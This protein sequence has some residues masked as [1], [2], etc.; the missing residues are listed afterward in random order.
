MDRRIDDT[1]IELQGLKPSI[2]FISSGGHS[3][4]QKNKEGERV[5][6]EA[7][8]FTAVEAAKV[9]RLINPTAVALIGMY[10]HSI[11]KNRVEY[12][13]QSSQVEEEFLWALTY[14]DPNI[15][16]LFINPGFSIGLSE[17]DLEGKC[18]YFSKN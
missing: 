8:I 15:K 7:G 12:I 17:K 6:V 11:W 18:N 16:K 3:Q 14:L 4:L 9:T 13:R 1:W 2:L 5:V 10:N